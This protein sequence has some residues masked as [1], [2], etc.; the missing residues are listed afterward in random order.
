L[1]WGG[2]QLLENKIPHIYR[3][4]INIPT[5][6]EQKRFSIFKPFVRQ[7]GDDHREAWF[8]RRKI[9]DYLLLYI[10]EGYGTFSIGDNNYKIGADDILWI[11]PNVVHET[12]GTSKSMNCIYIH[13]DLVYDSKRSHW[14]AFIPNGVTE[15]GDWERFV[16]PP[17]NDR[18]ISKFSGLIQNSNKPAIKQ[19]M[20][21]ICIEH[22]R[23]GGKSFLL[24]SGMMMQIISMIISEYERKDNL[25]D[26]RWLE[27]QRSAASIRLSE[28]KTLDIKTLASEIKLS[29]SHFRKLFRE[30]HG[31]SPIKLHN[32]VKIQRACEMLVYGN[33]N[34]SEIAQK[35]GFSNVHNFSRAFKN[36]TKTSPLQYKKGRY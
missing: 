12:R 4:E 30:L 33:D 36:Y 8:A 24:L 16:H 34:I 15:F 29:T 28:E 13:F 11:P 9:L 3:R 25:N 5:N 1:L 31:I 27:I 26:V 23:S 18:T 21:Q 32:Q 22:R 7:A 20:K 6:D 2:G 19:L 35:L 17:V 10:G 14:N